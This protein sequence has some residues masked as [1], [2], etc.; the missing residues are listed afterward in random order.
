MLLF[1]CSASPASS[2]KI[3]QSIED[4]FLTINLRNSS[5]EE[6]LKEISTETGFRFVYDKLAPKR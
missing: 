1:V 3:P 4:I 5:V 2:Q 6:V